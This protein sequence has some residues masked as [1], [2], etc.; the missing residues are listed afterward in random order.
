V[1]P[2][3][4]VIRYVQAV[5]DGDLDTIVAS[6]TEDAT[7][8]YPG[9]VPLTGTWKGRDAIINDFL[10]GATGGLFAADGAPTVELTNVIAEG[11]QV[12]AEWTAKGVAKT[13]KVYDNAC[14]GV[15]T[16]RDGKIASVREYTDTQHVERVLFTP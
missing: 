3:D 10:G 2:K 5:A 4:V 12:V 15:F 8:T 7:W 11:D 9:D 16:V 1:N 13:G 6:F 14:L